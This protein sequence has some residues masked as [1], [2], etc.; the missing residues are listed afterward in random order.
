M[1]KGASATAEVL[2]KGGADVHAKDIDGGTPLHWAAHWD[3]SATAE[4]LLKEGADVYA[5]DKFGWTPLH[6][7]EEIRTRSVAR[8][9]RSYRGQ[10]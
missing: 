10:K 7:A 6:Y 2:L 5:K 8:L 1:A 9:L 4:V 3:A